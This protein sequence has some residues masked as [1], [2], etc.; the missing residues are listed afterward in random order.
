MAQDA[1][2]PTAPALSGAL[3]HVSLPVRDAARSAAFYRDVLGLRQ[4]ERPGFDFQGAWFALGPGQLHLIQD[5]GS[6]FREDKPVDARDIHFAI[7]VASYRA[8][9]LHLIARGYRKEGTPGAGALNGIKVS[10]RATAGFPQ[11]YLLDPDRNV[12]EINADTLDIAEDEVA[13]LLE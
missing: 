6:T 8:A 9:L 5:S 13:R 2:T 12:I 7:R 3:H 11:I 10:P 1:D 4:I